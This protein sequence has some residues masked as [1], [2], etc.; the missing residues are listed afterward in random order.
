MYVKNLQSDKSAAKVGF[1]SFVWMKG[2]NNGA[3]NCS[4]LIV[5]RNSNLSVLNVGLIGNYPVVQT[6]SDCITSW[7]IE[8]GG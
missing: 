3:S 1:I 2:S 5:T 4:T 6:D 8:I 7:C